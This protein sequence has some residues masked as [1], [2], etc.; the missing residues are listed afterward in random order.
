MRLNNQ[1]LY[2][3]F[4]EKNIPVLYHA[5]T[6]KTSLTYFQQNG[7]LSRGAV[8][9]LGLV[10]T[11]QSSDEA[12]Q[13]LNVWNDIFLD[14]TDLHSFFGRQNYYGPILFELD[15]TFLQNY[16][17]EIW[18]TKDNPIYWSTDSTDEERYFQNVD[19][20]REDWGKYQRQ[21]KMITIR[22][23][24]T[25]ILFDYVRKVIVDDPRVKIPDGNGDYIH[26]FN[27]AVTLIKELVPDGHILKG[28]FIT[29]DCTNCWCRDNYLTQVVQNELKRL[30]L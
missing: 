7:L 27:E 26:L 23:N 22:N 12:D 17:C 15:I 3:F 29:R 11:T 8:E 28:K 16:D 1:I 25:P 9:Q 21:K 18:I 30:F 6:V 19:E 20:L 4:I 24:S 10:Q 5:N 2:D 13:V 14:S